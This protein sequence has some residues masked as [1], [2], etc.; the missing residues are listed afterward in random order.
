MQRL[1]L[2]SGAAVLCAAV[3]ATLLVF[4]ARSA[5]APPHKRLYKNSRFSYS[6]EVPRGWLVNESPAGVASLLNFPVSQAGPQGLFPMEG[7][8]I[9]LIPLQAVE[10]VTGI[11]SL[12]EWI[13]HNLLHGR[14]N[15]LVRHPPDLAGGPGRPVDLVE[16][17]ADFIRDIQDS[18]PQYEVSYYFR[19]DGAMFRAMLLYWKH[20][21]DA[22]R[23]KRT[24]EEVVRS[25]R[26][27]K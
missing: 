9:D 22:A 12:E 19:L 13:R 23:L 14:S 20:N 11:Q 24:C 6:L 26:V 10:P 5:A 18:E 17:E 4:T 21:Q 15:A 27:L 1:N 3:A 25:V 8:V 16:V 7:A 2:G